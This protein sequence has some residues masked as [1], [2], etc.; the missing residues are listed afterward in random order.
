MKE[1]ILS[2]YTVK[3]V[4]F[5]Y[6]KIT[7]TKK[8]TTI[9]EKSLTVLFML[10]MYKKALKLQNPSISSLRVS[11]LLSIDFACTPIKCQTPSPTFRTCVYD[12]KYQ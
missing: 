6:N 3:K 8:T 4:Y 5:P 12:K 2:N 7:T 1:N 10:H 11:C 9:Y